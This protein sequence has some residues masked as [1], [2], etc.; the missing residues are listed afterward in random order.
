MKHLIK[1]QEVYRVST[2]A[3]AEALI[4]EAK[5]DN[6]FVLVKYN[7]ESKEVKAKGEIVDEWYQV[8]LVK[9]FNDEKEPT[10]HISLCYTNRTNFDGETN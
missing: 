6:R 10:D 7:C 9:K 5:N 4:A 2:D 8:T 3:E 1:V